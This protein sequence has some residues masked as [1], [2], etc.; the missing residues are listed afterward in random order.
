MKLEHLRYLL[1]V[2]DQGSITQAAERLY[3]SQPA[4]SAAIKS[5][6]N[7]LGYPVFKR[8]KQG[9]V[10]TAKGLQILQDIEKIL[11]ITKKWHSAEVYDEQI[12]GLVRFAAVP[13]VNKAFLV[14]IFKQTNAL[15]PL[16]QVEAQEI[17]N[18]DICD[19]IHSNK[20][21]IGCVVAEEDYHYLM[22]ARDNLIVKELLKDDFVLQLSAK[23]PLASKEVIEKADLAEMP[24]VCYAN[25]KDPI[26]IALCHTYGIEVKYKVSSTSVIPQM[27]AADLAFSLIPKY[28]AL[29]EPL[30]KFGD[31]VIRDFPGFSYP[32]SYC[33]IWSKDKELMPHEE[34]FISALQRYFESVERSSEDMMKYSSSYMAHLRRGLEALNSGQGVE[35]ELIEE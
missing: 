1:E 9:V 12:A 26:Q 10:A 35:H 27:I 11:E 17:P 20:N 16:L 8:S 25:P 30:L 4:L 22:E 18:W 29:Q 33:C 15:Y 23:N 3:I 28:A 21:F 6:E 19:F 5:I 24:F 34:A 32:V 7:E 2:N 31:I 14:D 13:A